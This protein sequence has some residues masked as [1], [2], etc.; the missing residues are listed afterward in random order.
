MPERLPHVHRLVQVQLLDYTPNN[1]IP[2]VSL[3]WSLEFA[4]SSDSNLWMEQP[5][6]V[7]QR[8]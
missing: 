4:D 8:L 6:E 1:T 3:K 2:W 7:D 5:A